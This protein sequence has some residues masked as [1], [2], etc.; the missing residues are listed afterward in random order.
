VLNDEPEVNFKGLYRRD[1]YQSPFSSSARAA[2][3]FKRIIDLC[4]NQKLPLVISY[5]SHG[6]VEITE[7]ISLLQYGYSKVV[8]SEAKYSHSMQGR[9]VVQDRTEFVLSGF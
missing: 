6:L 7:L 3:S 2:D 5:S 1:R 9:G 4:S 8:V